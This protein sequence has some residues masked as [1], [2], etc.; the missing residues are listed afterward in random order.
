ML[1]SH[2]AATPPV[3]A[4]ESSSGSAAG[5]GCNGA[6][7]LRPNL[8]APFPAQR[9]WRVAP[10]LAEIVSMVSQLLLCFFFSD[11]RSGLRRP[12]VRRRFI[13]DTPE[14]EVVVA[15]SQAA[16]DARGQAIITG[17]AATSGAMRCRSSS[18]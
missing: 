6:S 7:S 4:G 15:P 3:D 12:A 1:G 18:S 13:V 5:T 11:Q 9:R 2:R 17:V 8:H 16:A 10:L 14:D